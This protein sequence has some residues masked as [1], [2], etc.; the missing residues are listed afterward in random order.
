LARLSLNGLF[1]AV[2]AASVT[3][4][5]PVSAIAQSKAIVQ[6][7]RLVLKRDYKR[8]AAALK[9]AV[10]SGDAEAQFRLANLHL[11]GLGLPRD[12]VLAR[13]LLVQAAAKGNQKAQRLLHRIAAAGLVRTGSIA[14]PP[15]SSAKVFIPPVRLDDRDGAGNSWVVRAASR[16][17]TAALASFVSARSAG[18]GPLLAAAA[19][20]EADA[21]ELLIGSGSPVDAADSSGRTAL[22]LAAASSSPVLSGQF[23][24][25]GADAELRDENGETALHHAIRGCNA[26]AAADLLRSSKLPAE[27]SPGQPYLQLASQYCP[28]APLVEALIRFAGPGGTDGFGRGPLWHA[29]SRGQAD[30]VQL[31]IFAGAEVSPVDADGMTAVHAAIRGCHVGI[32]DALLQSKADANAS[33]SSGDTPLILAAANHCG[34]GMARLIAAGAEIDT[35]NDGGDTAL[36]QA[37]ASA[38]V[39]G[40]RLLI[41]AGADMNARN[42][43]RE[44]P[45]SL[46]RRLGQ[47][48]M[49]KLLASP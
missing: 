9:V 33:T 49:L 38:N 23:L 31:L 8:A 47:P 26:A 27:A 6:S 46:A 21:V 17:Q 16:G 25:A 2:L 29:A 43:R 18:T 14:R 12:V 22:M 45:L 28:E 44:T 34:E 36:L 37:V 7:D 42:S 10:K 32:L 3:I 48:S 20:G 1:A 24:A 11:I 39:T 15:N 41:A 13:Q 40:A 19:A 30:L 4:A 5:Q 35:A